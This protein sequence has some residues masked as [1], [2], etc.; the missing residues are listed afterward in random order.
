M[1]KEKDKEKKALLDGKQL[2]LKITANSVYGQCGA[3]TSTIYLKAIAAS[4]TAT[5]RYML[6]LARDYMENDFP[7][8][9][10]EIY[11]SIKEDNQVEFNKILDKELKE[12]DNNNFIETMKKQLVEIFDTYTIKPVTMYGDTDSV[13]ID[14]YI[15]DKEGIDLESKQGL[16]YAINLGEIA[17]VLIKSRLREPQD[18]EY[19]KTFG[20]FV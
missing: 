6:E 11:N 4:T 17:G 8:I 13:F 16:I 15:Q 2:A 3:S 20:H 12:R 9:V 14:F 10:K 7:V 5:G 1:K 19:E 18:L